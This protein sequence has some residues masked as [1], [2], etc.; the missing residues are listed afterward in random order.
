MKQSMYT[1][2]RKQWYTPCIRT[3]ILQKTTFTKVHFYYC[4]VMDRSTGVTVLLANIA[5]C[6]LLLVPTCAGS[7][8]GRRTTHHAS[9]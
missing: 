1:I 9:A 3:R 4:L 8:A 7:H 2:L 5:K 6:H